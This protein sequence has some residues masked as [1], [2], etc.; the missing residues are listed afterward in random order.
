MGFGDERA[1]GGYRESRCL[2]Q[3]TG[4]AAEVEV[5]VAAAKARLTEEQ[6]EKILSTGP[7]AADILAAEEADE[8]IGFR[9]GASWLAE[10]LLSGEAVERAA[11]EVAQHEEVYDENL[12]RMV[13]ACGDDYTEGLMPEH[14]ARAALSAALGKE[15]GR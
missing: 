5:K 8:R 1:D 15:Q 11:R 9:R 7:T 12:D 3:V 6:R 14:I 10:H 2:P 4:F 13:C